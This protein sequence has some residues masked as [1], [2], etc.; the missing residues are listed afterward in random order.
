VSFVFLHGFAGTPRT[1]D[2]WRARFG[3]IAPTIL[4][5]GATSSAA[6]FDEEVDRLATLAPARSTWVGY[7][8]GGR[9]ALGVAARHPDRIARLVLIAAHPG[10]EDPNERAQR[11]AEDEARARAL[12]TEGLDRFFR[13]WDALPMFAR[14]TPPHREGLVA[15]ELARAMRVLSPGATTPRWDTLARHDLTYVVG[16]HDAAYRAL[17]AHVL[18]RAPHTRVAIVPGADHDV[19]GCGDEARQVMESLLDDVALERAI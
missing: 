18:A 12:E 5:H 11:R 9:L 3:G 1:F 14:R 13:A 15:H 7:S 2:P 8:M 16:E 6:T 10:I 17:A 19:L 4:G